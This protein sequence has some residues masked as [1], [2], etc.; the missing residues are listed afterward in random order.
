M[1]VFLL[2]FGFLFLGWFGA[3]LIGMGQFGL[4]T[5][6]VDVGFKNHRLEGRAARIVSV[7]LILVG[8]VV[9]APF[10]YGISL[11]LIDVVKHKIR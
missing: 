11:L 3:R 10:V 1:G 9:I 8:I 6:T 7:L 5:H 2:V 4:K